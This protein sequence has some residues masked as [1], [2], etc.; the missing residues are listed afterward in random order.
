M[1]TDAKIKAAMKSVATELTLNDKS[2]GRGAGSLLLVIR[3]QAAGGVSAQ[4]FAKVKRAG[5]R[6][7]RALGRYPDMTL[8]MA[9]QVMAAEVT[10]ALVA[11][12]SL[13]T[14]H[15][16]ER[17]TVGA[18][19]AAYVASLRARTSTCADEVERVLNL[20]AESFGPGRL[21]GDIV[22][23]DLVEFVS[24]YY[25]RGKAGAADKA[26]AYVSAAFG[27]ARRS[28]NDVTNPNRRDWGVKLNPATDVP[29][30]QRGKNARDRTLTAAE[31]RDLW[32][33]AAA[34]PAP[35]ARVVQLLICT[36]QRVEETL[37]LE[38]QEIDLEAMN[39]R[40]PQEKTK[41][42]QRAHTVPLPAQA[43]PILAGLVAKRPR[44][45]LFPATGHGAKRERMDHRSVQQ[46]ID[47]TGLPKFQTRDL[48]RTWKSR[49][50]DAG[51]DRF[52]RDLI[53]QHT[54]SDAGTVHYD[55]ADYLPQMREAM[56]KWAAWLND[57]VV[58]SGIAQKRA[59]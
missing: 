42:R 41:T 7:K 35:A 48:R 31:L 20:A 2:A 27:W 18:M 43:L 36:G 56:T 3:R 57:H 9:R 21:A 12:K 59:A 10:P 25:Q 23:A 26:R 46:W 55:R 40:M 32:D 37:R 5:K 4:W 6:T 38:A 45:A 50:H 8:A 29:Q 33:A 22:D 54:G 13:R 28:A 15:H 58:K 51:V 53:Q 52:T 24:G 19:F 14:V 49:A 1:L 16:G 44:G 30:V 39:W 47:R 34:S 17:P 11:G